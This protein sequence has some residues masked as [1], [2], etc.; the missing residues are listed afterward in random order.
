M[1]QKNCRLKYVAYFLSFIILTITSCQ[2]EVDPG[3]YVPPTSVPPS[4]PN[5]ATKVIATL[6]G[7][8]IDENKQPVTNTTVT[9]GTYT[10]TT[11]A[12]GNFTFRNINISK[13]NGHVVV[14]KAGYFKSIRSFVTDAGKTNVVKI[15]LIKQSLSGTINS[16]AGGVVN[17][18]GAT[19]TF[20]AN[21]FVT[22]GGT[23]Y[24]GNVK[25][26]AT[27]IDPT[28]PNLP[29]IVPGDL[30]GI[31]SNNVEFLLKSYGMVGAELK[32][33]NGNIVRI[34]PA[35]PASIS[36]P[37]PAALQGIA[38]AMIPLWHFN[39]AIAR[40]KEEGSATK[41]GNS[42]TAQVNKFSF[43]NVDVP[44]DFINLD[45]R[46]INS[47][48]NLPLANAM[49][50]ITSLAT[51]T[52]AYDYTNDSGYVS[53]YVPKDEPLKLEVVA[54][55][56]CNSN[57]L[58][59]TQN[60]GP[61]NINTSLGNVSITVPVSL[62]ITFTGVIKN[63][64]NLP[65]TNGYISL[66]LADGTSTIAYANPSGEVN[67]S[68]LHCGGNNIAY[69]YNAV[70]LD[71][72]AYSTP[73]NGTATGNIV[74]LDTIRA[75]GNVANTSGVYIAGSIDNRAVFWKDGVV[76]YLTGVPTNPNQSAAAQK[77][78]VRND[79]VYAL[80][81]DIE[82]TANGSVYIIKL[83]KN[84]VLTNITNGT[85]NA[86]AWGFDVY[87]GDV[88]VAGNIIGGNSNDVGKVWKNGVASNLPRDTFNYVVATGVKVVNGDI[89]VTR[90]RIA[91]SPNI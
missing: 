49:V 26:Y 30:R 53:G 31:D 20:P 21:G 32:D 5:D 54:A 3:D 61:Y 58:V 37:I 44:E 62:S 51:N 77:I 81:A 43:W 42:Y 35:K 45:M 48:N 80:V 86:A 68:I 88:Y 76:T 67:F 65:V 17:V 73:T 82:P 89:F 15:Q 64:N 34:N 40:W 25:V 1:L 39:E 18:N 84:G 52:V 38:P 50:K 60:A 57:T 56:A 59:H 11:D 66:S 19:I 85:I 91:M 47:T 33:D 79:D 27:W 29:F 87:N 83:W 7:S 16:A 8:V 4:I 71:A 75:C 23:A 74:N 78:L 72:G 28:S 2:K 6:T 63:C 22:S 90:I 46:L 69:A 14:S 9:T 36:F 55:T 13:A 70:D 24:T 12:R 41:V 10:T